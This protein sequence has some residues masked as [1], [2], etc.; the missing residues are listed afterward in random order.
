MDFGRALTANVITPKFAIIGYLHG[1]AATECAT[2]FDY[3]IK[4][5]IFESHL[6]PFESIL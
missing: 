5:I 6:P 1:K 3:Q 4:K 2:D